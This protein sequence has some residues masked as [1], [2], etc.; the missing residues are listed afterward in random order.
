M[1]CIPAVLLSLACV[2]FGG[3]AALAATPGSG[4]PGSKALASGSS[5]MLPEGVQAQGEFRYAT[6]PVPA[7]VAV[8]TVPDES[9]PP[10]A[11]G[12]QWRT[13]LFDSQVDHRGPREASYEDRAYEA[14]SNEL[15]KVS[16]VGVGM[17]SHTGVAARMFKALSDAKINI[18]NITTSE[19]KISCIS[20]K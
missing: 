14:M 13:W 8:S 11:G 3:G 18:Q 16:V 17:R 15:A 12:T 19:I 5:S 2:Y 9:P 7:W 1:R 6:G 20:A 4:P 10:A